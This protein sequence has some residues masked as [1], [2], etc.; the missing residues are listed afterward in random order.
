MVPL[1]WIGARLLAVVVVWGRTHRPLDLRS[2]LQVDGN[3][4]TTLVVLVDVVPF[5]A[6]LLSHLLRVEAALLV[7][8][9][10]RG[11]LRLHQGMVPLPRCPQVVVWEVNLLRV[12]AKSVSRNTMKHE[13]NIR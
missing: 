10:L 5:L 2:S 9:D 6:N 1:R 12:S 11:C 3:D 8:Q 13:S 4:G 7:L